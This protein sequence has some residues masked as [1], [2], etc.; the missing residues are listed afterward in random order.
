MPF[1]QTQ[2]FDVFREYNLAVWPAQLVLYALALIAIPLAAR[3]RSSRFVNVVL[4]AFW[5]W[6]AIAYHLSFFAPI[7]RAAVGFAILFVIEALIFLWQG[8]IR[9]RIRF[10]AQRDLRTATGLALIVYAL[11]LYPALGYLL[12][13]RYPAMP[14]FGLPCPTTIFTFGLLLWTVLPFPRYVLVIPALWALLGTAAAISLSVAEDYG[15]LIAAIL[16][17]A[18]TAASARSRTR[19]DVVAT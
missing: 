9:G 4:A 6:M 18:W 15:L 10:R 11:L 14:T 3:A 1:T 16:S 12:G 5:A 13:R 8:V 19:S 17:L 7:N 2:F